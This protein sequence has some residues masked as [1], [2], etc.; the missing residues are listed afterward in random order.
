[1][2][3][4]L[5]TLNDPA[6]PS[7]TLPVLLSFFCRHSHITVSMLFLTSRNCGRTTKD[8]GGGKKAGDE[9]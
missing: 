9:Q 8:E 4:G 6:S 2:R 7:S 5:L 3:E 1:M